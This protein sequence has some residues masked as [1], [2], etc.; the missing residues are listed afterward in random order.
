MTPE[1][2]IC[3]LTM[4]HHCC[5]RMRP[6]TTPAGS[7]SPPPA[8]HDS[9]PIPPAGPTAATQTRGGEGQAETP[10]SLSTA[11]SP[12]GCTNL[13]EGSN[14]WFSSKLGTSTA[15]S[16]H[17]ETPS[18]LATRPAAP[19]AQ[20]VQAAAGEA[21]TCPAWKTCSRQWRNAPNS[22]RKSLVPPYIHLALHAEDVRVLLLSWLWGKATESSSSILASFC[23]TVLV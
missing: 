6:R 18:R 23:P 19:L 12:V 13:A 3:T 21:A 11:A 1:F 5:T 9:A 4:T 2:L 15:S 7:I 20:E 14:G 16:L 8:P 17:P 22:L 10:L